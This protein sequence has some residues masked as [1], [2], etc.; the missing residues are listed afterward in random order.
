MKRPIVYAHRGASGYAIENTIP[1]FELAITMKADAVEFDVQLM[2]DGEVVVFH[3]FDLGRLLH[4]ERSV[5]AL[6]AKDLK[7]IIFPDTPIPL[8]SE[9][10]DAIGHKIAMNIEL[11][12]QAEDPVILRELCARVLELVEAHD[13]RHDV[14][15]SSF[16]REALRQVRGL[17]PAIRMA[18][19]VDDLSNDHA[20]ASS[21]KTARDLCAYAVNTSYTSAATKIVHDLHGA[22][23]DVNVYTVNNDDLVRQVVRAGV[24]GLF[25]NYPDR[26]IAVL[27]E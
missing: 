24:D 26:A 23:L 17:S 27:E 10:L 14:V 20:V 8:L 3:D 25:T 6:T 4:I 9:V 13:L 19:L 2:H 22:G 1:S 11:K 18:V 21:L 12:S 16:N 7:K 15:I 5:S